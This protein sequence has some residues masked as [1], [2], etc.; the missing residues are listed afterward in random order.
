MGRTQIFPIQCNSVS[1]SFESDST[2]DPQWLSRI[3]SNQLTTQ[4]GLLEFDSNRLMVQMAFQNFDSN[5]LKRL[6]SFD[7]YQLTTQKVLQNFDSNPLTTHK[8]CGILIRINS[9]LNYTIMIGPLSHWIRLLMTFSG[10]VPLDLTWRDLFW[11]FDPNV[12][13]RN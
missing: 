11:A 8:L 1:E 4:K 10:L 3:D 6:S 12:F 2:R 5:R 7:S 13:L 9:W